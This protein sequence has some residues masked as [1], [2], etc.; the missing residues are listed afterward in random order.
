MAR[1]YSALANAIEYFDK[2]GKD[3]YELERQVK[4]IKQSKEFKQHMN[5]MN[6]YSNRG[7]IDAAPSF[8]NAYEIPDS[9]DAKGEIL[10]K[11]KF[12]KK[13]LDEKE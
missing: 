3:L 10:D 6:V 5:I 13:F 11:D 9:I 1:N 7:I 12:L 2:I 4:E 8:K